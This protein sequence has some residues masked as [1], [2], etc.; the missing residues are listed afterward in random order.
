MQSPF[1]ITL[2]LMLALLL[3]RPAIADLRVSVTIKPLHAI[4]TELMDGLP[5]PTQ[6]VRDGES[7]HHAQLRPS[8]LSQLSR[9]HLVVRVSPE[10]E[11]LLSK[12]I[13]NL[14]GQVP[15]ITFS[16]LNG[17][18]ILPAR[19]SSSHVNRIHEEH[20]TTMPLKHGQH[21]DL[22]LWLDTNNV[23]TLAHAIERKLSELD[24][25]NKALYKQNKATFLSQLEKLDQSIHK[26]LD[27]AKTDNVRII[28]FH[29]AF[30]YFERLYGITIAGFVSATEAHAPGTRHLRELQK[31]V[32]GAETLCFLS[33]PQSQQRLAD[34]LFSKHKHMIKGT[35]DPIGYQIPLGKNTYIELMEKIA[36][37]FYS[38]YLGK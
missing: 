10:L 6:L 2:L 7:P 8:T 11:G 9:S 37:A 20:P 1:R 34:N 27:A 14:Q 38:C 35:I 22:H 4:V 24:P 18:N 17:V 31:R 21:H 12:A 33:E 15:I 13:N 29:D 36:D 19:A 25:T 23:R 26:K 3:H 32:S 28:L 16:Q 5:P 30:Q